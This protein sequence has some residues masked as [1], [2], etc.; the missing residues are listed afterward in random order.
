M[1]WLDDGWGGVGTVFF[2]MEDHPLGIH[3]H[4][5]LRAV[6]TDPTQEVYCMR[7]SDDVKEDTQKNNAYVENESDR[8]LSGVMR[9]H[10]H[11]VVEF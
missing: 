9:S 4:V 11:R 7:S 1:G 6:I 2:V 3:I 5:L 8:C 10:G